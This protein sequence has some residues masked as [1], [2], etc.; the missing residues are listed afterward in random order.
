MRDFEVGDVVKRIKN[1]YGYVV[2]G[3]NY[4][5]ESIRGN[6]VKLVNVLGTYLQT[7]FNLVEKERVLVKEKNKS[8]YTFTTSSPEA[9]IWEDI[10]KDCKKNGLL[11]VENEATRECY[12]VIPD[13]IVQIA[14]KKEVRECPVSLLDT[15]YSAHIV[16]VV[17]EEIS[18]V[19]QWVKDVINAKWL[20]STPT[21]YKVKEL[22]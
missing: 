4:I 22:L 19:K 2:K 16:K 3:E 10:T 14:G 15:D 5:I 13:Y 21:T 7:G 11:L 8:E 9:I 18:L 6:C 17:H 1:N 12:L 20:D